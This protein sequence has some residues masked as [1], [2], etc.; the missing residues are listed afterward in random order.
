MQIFYEKK[1]AISVFLSVILLPMLIV[2]LLATDAARIYSA[3]SVIADAGEMAMNAALAQYNAK[4][5]DEYGLIAMDKEPSSMQGDLEKYFTASLNGDGL[6]NS[7]NYKQ[8]LDLMEQ[9][10][11]V[12]DVEASKVYKTEVEKQQIL[13]YMKYRAPVCMADMVLDKID[14]IKDNKKMIEAMEAEADF[15]EAMEECQDAFEDAKNKLDELNEQLKYFPYDSKINQD[16]DSTE[17]EY[18]RGG[19]SMAFMIRA[20]IGHYDDYNKTGVQN[21]ST[22]QQKFDLL[23]G[24][25]TSFINAA[26]QVSLGNPLDET[27]Y[28]QFMAAMYYKNTMDAL[29]GEGNLLTWYDELNTPADDEESDEEDSSSGGEDQARKDL[30]DSIT[31]YKNKR[32]AI[33]PGYKQSMDQYVRTNVY[34][35]GDTLN[36][37]WTSAQ[38]GEIRAKNAKDALNIVKEK[39]E[40]AA[41]K[42]AIWKEKTDALSNPGSMKDEVEKYENMFDTTKCEQLINKVESDEATFKRIQE[43]LKGEKFFD[44]SLATVDRGTQMQKFSNEA[45]YV[46]DNRD[47]VTYDEY[48]ELKFIC[49]QS[50]RT[51]YVHIHVTYVL[52]S[53]ENDEFY[54][55][56]IEYCKSRESTEKNEKQE[57][58][59]ETLDQGKEGAEEAKSEDGFPTYDWS[60]ASVTLP[61]RL[62]GYSSYG[63]NTDKLT[64][65]T[66]GDIDNKGDRKNIIKNVKESIKQ[67]NSF[68]D[69]VDRILS[70]GIENLYIAEYAMQMFTYYTVDKKV[71]ASHEIETLSGEN[72]TSL[73]GYEFSSSNHKAYKAE[74]EY[75][76]WGK[77]SSKKNVQATVAV[78]YGIRL[79]FNVFYALTD[80]KIDLYATGISAPWAA[81]APYLEPIIKLVVKLGLGL[82]ET[83]DDIKDIKGGYGVSLT[84]GKVTWVTLKALLSAPNADNTRGTLT[85]D[86]SEYLRLFLNTAML[87]AGYQPALARIGDCIQVNTDSDITK[88]STML[89]IEATV[90]NRTTFMRKIA[91]WS[92][93]GWQYGDSYSIDYKSVLG[94]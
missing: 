21:A 83:T 94:Y 61:S 30:S 6:S 23:N 93:A 77:S 67:A 24:A 8:V 34:K 82:C 63:A 78:I 66:G 72:L 33:M 4:L 19:L 56:L 18:K 38:S 74:T 47:C 44:Q 5:K 3:K 86:Y 40:N 57:Q 46:M 13:E 15:A 89:S 17:M 20:A 41:E 69:G 45:S 70:D 59:N 9:S 28:N 84:K 65:T 31:D 2:A 87:A 80:E 68:L 7:G 60:S 53:I 79:L 48:S 92:G 76:L 50:Y 12:I 62:L 42:H 90:T 91:D 37:Y 39:L 71:N 25:M 36:N 43:E 10:F 55:Q 49:D 32:D 27:S 22:T 52:Q 73:S 85:F 54:K 51:G 29:G 64:A 1:G 81:V 11:E 75:I 14:Q 26:K 35:W 16:L 58:A 88:M